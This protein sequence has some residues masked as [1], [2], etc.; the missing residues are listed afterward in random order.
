M[1]SADCSS[2]GDDRHRLF[3]V[4]IGAPFL[5]CGAEGARAVSRSP[6][7]KRYYSTN[8]TAS[9]VCRLLI[10]ANAPRTG[11][12]R[13]V[14]SLVPPNPPPPPPPDVRIHY[15]PT[16]P[17]PAPP[18]SLPPPCASV[19]DAEWLCVQTCDG[20]TDAPY[21]TPIATLADYADAESCV[22]VPTPDFAGANVNSEQLENAPYEERAAC[23]F[24]RRIIDQQR[25]AS[26]CFSNVGAPFPP[27]PPPTDL[28]DRQDVASAFR[29]RVQLGDDDPYPT[30]RANDAAQYQQDLSDAISSSRNLI[31][32][33][34]ESNPILKSL[35]GSAVQELQTAGGRRLM[36]RPEYTTKATDV[37]S[38]H[39]LM[40]SYGRGGIPG[41]S[42][43]SCEALCE[44]VTQDTNAS[45]TDECHAF[46][47]RRAAPFS[48]ADFTGVCLLLQTAGACKPHDFASALY[49]RHVQSET[50]CSEPAPGLD[51]PLCVSLPS[52]RT[53]TRVLTHS[54]ATAIAAQVPDPRNPAPGSGGLPNPRSTLEAMFFVAQA[55]AVGVS[56]F[57]AAIPNTEHGSV[58]THWYGQGG[59]HVVFAQGETRCILVSSA[60][61]R[62]SRMYAHLRACDAHL[63]DGVL[64]VAASAAVRVLQ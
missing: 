46:A 45:D 42:K 19:V 20:C 31:T 4:R 61:G 18:P 16:P 24:A 17:N 27:P 6:V 25:R 60:A 21:T 49:T 10:D 12:F 37:L 64:T 63:A 22:P 14:Y 38:T 57:W 51:A 15:G 58:T 54:D 26:S 59:V 62:V 8:Q 1:A 9:L 11:E 47:F 29:K 35:L 32:Q 23:V 43:A 36:Q 52:T 34:G 13:H 56:S 30:P 55:R 7:C 41:V 40:K 48:L 50:K 3:L 53:D 2:F 28:S 5:R 44:A 33:L 39:P